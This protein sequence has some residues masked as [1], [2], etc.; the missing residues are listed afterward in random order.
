[1]T[2]YFISRHPGAIEWAK[3]QGIQID[4]QQSHFDIKD[5]QPDDTIIGT[6]PIN[7]IAEVCKQGGK[8]L[9]LSLDLPADMR[10]KELNADDMQRYGARLE[11][12]SAE[13]ITQ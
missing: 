2:T 6:L 5:T 12:Y 4:K 3:Q 7:L 13:K 9:H 1:M 11:A 10:G 8:Y